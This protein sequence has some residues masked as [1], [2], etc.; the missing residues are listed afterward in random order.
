[1]IFTKTKHFFDKVIDEYTK[2]LEGYDLNMYGSG[3]EET[4]EELFTNEYYKQITFTKPVLLLCFNTD[5]FEEEKTMH[6]EIKICTESAEKVI[7][8][9]DHE[10]ED[11]Y[12]FSSEVM[13]LTVEDENGIK[14]K[15]RF[16]SE[17]YHIEE[18]EEYNPGITK[19]MQDYMENEKIHVEDYTVFLI[20]HN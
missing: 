3:E 10:A 1:M 2:E 12:P 7:L 13:M 15:F 16:N 9:T 18:V 4:I 8:Y 19:A 20:S 17:F 11:R 14:R 6:L 5:D